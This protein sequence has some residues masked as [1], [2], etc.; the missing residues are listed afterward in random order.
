[1]KA[2]TSYTTVLLF[3]VTMLLSACATPDGGNISID[4]GNTQAHKEPTKPKVSKKNGPPSHAPA[5]GY[6]IR[7]SLKSLAKGFG[8]YFS[9]KF[10]SSLS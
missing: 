7:F 6:R 1:M 9:H 8:S 3:L 2:I 4:W 10:C 5:H